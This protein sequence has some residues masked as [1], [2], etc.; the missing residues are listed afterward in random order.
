[1]IM[2]VVW[3][4]DEKTKIRRDIK[5]IKALSSISEITKRNLIQDLCKKLS[6]L[7]P[8]FPESKENIS[9]P[10][11]E[12][13]TLHVDSDWWL[14]EKEIN[15]YEKWE[16]KVKVKTNHDWDIM[17]ILE[18]PSKWEQIF[19]TYDAF[20]FYACKYKKCSKKILE[21]KYLPTPEKL[22]LMAGNPRENSTKYKK[23]RKSTIKDSQLTGYYIPR[24]EKLWNFAK[25]SCIWLAGGWDA[26]F[27]DD[28]WNHDSGGK[29]YG[30]SGRLLKG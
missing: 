5:S 16:W 10:G 6:D 27:L 14:E 4:F 18:W 12:E 25:R 19:L 2:R 1:M 20:V 8:A 23:F 26:D 28:K 3:N 15:L 21:K 9:I 13:N 29:S 22:V 30:F 7:M 17:E 24:G 11:F